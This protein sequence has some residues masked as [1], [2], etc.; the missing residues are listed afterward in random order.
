LSRE[1][2]VVG[3]SVVDVGTKEEVGARVVTLDE[4]EGERVGVKA[5]GEEVGREVF[6]S[7]SRVG[8][9][10]GSDSVLDG[11]KEGAGDGAS[12]TCHA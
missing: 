2:R 8:V 6:E 3:C 4:L 9:A 11:D 7:A 12:A 1:E 10:V 5:E